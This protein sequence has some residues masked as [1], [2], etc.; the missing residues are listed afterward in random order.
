MIQCL[1]N[2]NGVVVSDTGPPPYSCPGALLWLHGGASAAQGQSVAAAR[3][4][5][6]RIVCSFLRSFVPFRHHS[7]LDSEVTLLA[8]SP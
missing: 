2:A 1:A 6:V 5:F 3:V 4:C 7:H 8:P